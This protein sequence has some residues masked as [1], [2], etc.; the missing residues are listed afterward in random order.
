M[1]MIAQLLPWI[2]PPVLGA[3]IGYVTNAIAIRMLFRPF[4]EIRVL[5]LRL[6]FTPGLIPR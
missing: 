4:N 5:G 3:I 1:A 6:P 2:L